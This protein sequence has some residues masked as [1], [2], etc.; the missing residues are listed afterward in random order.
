V[1]VVQ[2]PDLGTASQRKL[3]SLYILH[4][5]LTQGIIS[6]LFNAVKSHSIHLKP[7]HLNPRNRA[8]LESKHQ[9]RHFAPGHHLNP[10]K[11]PPKP[12]NC[13]PAHSKCV[14]VATHARFDSPPTYSPGEPRKMP[15]GIVL[16]KQRM[17][18]RRLID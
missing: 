15:R 6:R 13:L 11:P 3:T 16:R 1:P 10:L 14:V 2:I 18:A 7:Q 5:Q 12:Q 8:S 9:N 4:H 17:E